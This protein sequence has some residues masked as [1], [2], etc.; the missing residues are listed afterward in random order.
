[1][2]KNQDDYQ[3]RYIYHTNRHNNAF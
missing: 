2:F 3:L 1:M